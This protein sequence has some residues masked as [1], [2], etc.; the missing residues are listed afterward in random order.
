M[1]VLLDH[2]WT[3]Q[4]KEQR[5]SFLYSSRKYKHLCAECEYSGYGLFVFKVSVYYLRSASL[6]Y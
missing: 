2:D 1:E 3:F 5:E 4:S 6:N